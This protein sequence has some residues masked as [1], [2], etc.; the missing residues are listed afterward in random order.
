MR[1]E[2]SPRKI[3]QPGPRPAG[4]A[5]LLWYIDCIVERMFLGTRPEG[6]AAIRL[7]LID[8]NEQSRKIMGRRLAA[9]GYNVETHGDVATGAQAALAS[10]PAAIIADLWMPS[11]SGVQL[12]RLL[13]AEPA[14]AH[15]PI[16]L[17]GAGDDQR[18]RFWAGRAGA[19]AYV[20]KGRM[21]ELAQTLERLTREGTQAGDD[22]FFMQLSDDI[23]IRDRIAKQLDSALFE[24]VI[25]A[26]V[27]ALSRH[28]NF[29]ELFDHLT[30]LLS[31]V[32]SYRW[33]AVRTERPVRV[34]AHFHPSVAPEVEREIR[35]AFELDLSAPLMCV[36]DEDAQRV[37]DGRGD[38]PLIRADITIDALLLGQ[39][40]LAPTQ[41]AEVDTE[42]LVRLIANELG[43]PIR[44][45]ELVDESRRLATTDPLS[46]LLN[47]RAFSEKM[48]SEI[49]RTRR[50]SYP[51][52]LLLFDIDHFKRIN[53]TLGHAA[54]DE[55]IKQT[56]ALL[57]SQVRDSDI[58]ARWGGE[59]F[60]VALLSTDVGG[61]KKTAER[62]RTALES[63]QIG[64]SEGP[65]RVTSSIGVA[66]YS[67]DD[68][69]A[70]LVERADD[71]MYQA[72]KS[73]R[74]RVV[75]WGTSEEAAVS[76]STSIAVSMSAG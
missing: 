69:L 62:I 61:A 58:I 51:L 64:W 52:S 49:S 21:A 23:D 26:E 35:A 39:L 45:A 17:R 19:A 6:S 22:G 57:R 73:G 34:A 29:E 43:S 33:L 67:M 60:V 40:V 66:S 56:A 53:D 74:N 30:Q 72:K 9:Q 59:E 13:R 47:R 14:T 15:V 8:A 1:L 36:V 50:Y 3:G 46:K 24:S 41:D 37:V 11:I 63:L 42:S 71:A 54:G 25:A 5:R 76:S 4:R 38:F 48:A 20:A 68:S 12:C 18:S 65:I 27:R 28:G 44:I 2:T 55:V 75:T 32:L 10:P 7:L 70:D 31:Q 16:V